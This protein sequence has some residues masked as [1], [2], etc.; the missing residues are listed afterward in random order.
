MLNKGFIEDI[1]LILS[2]ANSN[3]QTHL[4]SATMTTEIKKLAEKYMKGQ[5]F[6][7]AKS[8]EET[9]PLVEQHYYEVHRGDQFN[10]L[11]RLTTFQLTF[12]ELFFNT[13]REVDD[14]SEKMIQRGYPAEALRDLSQQ[15]RNRVLTK[16]RGSR[17]LF[18]T[19]VA[20]RG[21]IF[22]I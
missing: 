13:K 7:E 16:S 2:M 1:E 21:L 10:A 19:D 3:R 15:Q 6:I 5:H 20:S 9:A 12:M 8:K 22:K 17:I 4:F 14:I 18:A 11:C